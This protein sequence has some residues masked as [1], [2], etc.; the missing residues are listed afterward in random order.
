MPSI[1]QRVTVSP[2]PPPTPQSSDVRSDPPP[3]RS[4]HLPTAAPDLAPFG[5]NLSPHGRTFHPPLA[6][7]GGTGG[8]RGSAEMSVACPSGSSRAGGWI[9]GR[10]A[11]RLI[12]SDSQ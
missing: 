2:P 12:L 3:F 8:D 4:T 5:R 7:R 6:V 10:L 11:I 9:N 1:R